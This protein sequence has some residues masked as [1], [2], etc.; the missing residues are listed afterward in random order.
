MGALNAR[1]EVPSSSVFGRKTSAA[2]SVVMVWNFFVG[3]MLYGQGP[4]LLLLLL[5]AA[6]W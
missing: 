2:E 3:G 6:V 5:L 4:L 1:V